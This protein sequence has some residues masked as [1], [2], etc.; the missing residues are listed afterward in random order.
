MT[1]TSRSPHLAFTSTS[2]LSRKRLGNSTMRRQWKVRHRDIPYCDLLLPSM[3]LFEGHR[4]HTEAPHAVQLLSKL[5]VHQLIKPYTC[6]TWSLGMRAG[7]YQFPVASFVFFGRLYTDCWKYV[8]L[9]PQMSRLIR[10][11]RSSRSLLSTFRVMLLKTLVRD[12]D[13]ML[14]H[15]L[16]HSHEWLREF[17]GNNAALLELYGILHLIHTLTHMHYVVGRGSGW[18]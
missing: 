8:F 6:T 4:S 12:N 16:I 14:H 1:I 7:G 15:P 10:P 5:V 9:Q 18:Q 17:P 2:C 11:R 3:A 13:S